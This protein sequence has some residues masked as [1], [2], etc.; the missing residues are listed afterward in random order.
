MPRTHP[1][2]PAL[3]PETGAIPDP[4]AD[5]PD[6]AADIPDPNEVNDGSTPERDAGTDR[7][8]NSRAC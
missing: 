1:L 6:P 4:A 7:D 3:P 8:D 5:V 2:D